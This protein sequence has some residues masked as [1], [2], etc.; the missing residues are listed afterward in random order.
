[1]KRTKNE[2][3][4]DI[5]KNA[6][7]DMA[8]N[9]RVAVKA[10]LLINNESSSANT[11]DDCE[12]L[13]NTAALRKALMSVRDAIYHHSLT[14]QLC[15]A[16]DVPVDKIIDEA[17]AETPRNCDRP[18]CATYGDAVRTLEEEVDDCEDPMEW[19]LAKAG[20]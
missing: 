15:I 8:K 13:S 11:D 16:S 19:L 12:Q 6:L 3:Q 18:E 1:M 20:K 17:L 10:C 5:L 14:G 9:L 4:H 2:S 7:L